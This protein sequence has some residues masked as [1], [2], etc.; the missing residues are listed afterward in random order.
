MTYLA[1]NADVILGHDI[2]ENIRQVHV[3]SQWVYIHSPS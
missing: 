3:C 1:E 2:L